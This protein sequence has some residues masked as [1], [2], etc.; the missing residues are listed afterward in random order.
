[1]V[2]PIVTITNDL[3]TGPVVDLT[4]RE[5]AAEGFDREEAE[6]SLRADWADRIMKLFKIGNIAMIALVGVMALVDAI[7]IGLR[8]IEPNERLITDGVVMA[9]IAATIAQVGAAGV[10][11]TRSLFRNG[12]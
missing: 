1:M 8:W 12:A 7:F 3:P 4:A 6:H 11:I 2:E 9:V 10:A 5:A